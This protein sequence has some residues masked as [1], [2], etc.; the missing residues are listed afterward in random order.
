[1]PE[2]PI[3]VVLVDDHE[4]MRGLFKG[5]IDLQPDI[6]VVGEADNGMDAI[7]KVRRLNPDVV[8]MDVSMPMMDGMETT[9][10]LKAEWP[11]IRVIGL[12]M[13]DY[14]YIAPQALNS[15]MDTVVDKCAST[16]ELIESIYGNT[17]AE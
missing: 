14:S 16:K 15:G 10:I 17:S 13:H 1:M 5:I 6:E 12:T 8:L 3:K 9:R 4:L 7:E 11:H 2:K